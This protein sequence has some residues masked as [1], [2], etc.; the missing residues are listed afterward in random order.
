MNNN[1]DDF[2][3]EYSLTIARK[4]FVRQRA[5]L[6]FFLKYLNKID[7]SYTEVTQQDVEVFLLSCKVTASTRQQYCVI[8]K[9]YYHFC[10]IEPNPV[11]NIK[12]KTR[13]PQKLYR[14][15]SEEDLK[16]LLNNGQYH[17]EK[18]LRNRLII[19]LA[20]GSGIRRSE[21]CKLNVESVSLEEMTIDVLGKG[22]KRRIIP[23]THETGQT[24][25]EYLKIRN[26]SVGPLLVTL[27]EQR[28]LGNN[29]IYHIIRDTTGYNPHALRHAC[30]T[31]MLKNGCST[32]V[33]QELLGHNSLTST[34]IYTNLDKR[35]L[36][37]VLENKHPRSS[38]K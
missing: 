1:L 11:E 7:L 32:R 20:Y 10:S 6:L 36:R 25:R 22:N 15:P 13:N 34:Q 2:L 33:I 12:I 37:E 3:I 9:R 26:V 23:I 31:H 18:A 21:L 4:T 8:I 35:D 24:L 5:Q 16:D 27:I 30:A 29:M 38:Q 28:R 14:V 19:E 17:S